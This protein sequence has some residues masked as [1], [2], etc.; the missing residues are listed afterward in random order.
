MNLYTNVGRG[1]WMTPTGVAPKLGI[2]ELVA[3]AVL[4]ELH[5]RV[6]RRADRGQAL[7][8]VVESRD[9]HQGDPGASCSESVVRPDRVARGEDPQA[10]LRSGLAHPDVV[11]Q[12]NVDFEPECRSDVQR[13][14]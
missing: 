6:G 2:P 8:P 4:A 12:R 11:D 5:G 13:V 1:F 3:C 14:E 9:G 7:R 10:V